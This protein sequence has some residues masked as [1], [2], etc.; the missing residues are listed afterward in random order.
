MDIPGWVAGDPIGAIVIGGGTASNGASQISLAGTNNG[1]NLTSARN[2]FTYDDHVAFTHGIHQFEAGA[3]VQ[4]IQAN[5]NLAQSQYGQAS[6][7]SL[8]SFLAGK[9]STF[10]VVPNPTPVGWR[11]LEGA[12]FVQ[13]NMKLRPNLELR[14]DGMR[15]TVG[16]RTTYSPAGLFRPSRILATRCSP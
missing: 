10:S 7:G 12:G 14:M 5:D 8:A 9:I 2:L 15:R 3:W 16:R 4:R 13:D 11:T 1:S 6:F